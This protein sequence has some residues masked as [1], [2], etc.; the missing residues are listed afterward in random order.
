MGMGQ[1]PKGFINGLLV[2][3][4]LGIGAG[5]MWHIG[6]EQLSVV[7]CLLVMAVLGAVFL[8]RRGSKGTWAAFAV[9]M[10]LL[11]LGR[12][13]AVT[14]PSDDDILHFEGQ[15]VKMSGVLAETP[16]AVFEADGRL[17]LRYVV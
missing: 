1:H 9:A 8:L 11:G 7:W 10:L 17:K 3:L 4:C 5:N 2:L 12:Y 6:R 14:V 15:K 16:Q 13:G